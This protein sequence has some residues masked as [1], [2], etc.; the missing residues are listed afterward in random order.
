[1]NS[2]VVSAYLKKLCTK[3]LFVQKVDEEHLAYAKYLLNI[4]VVPMV[5]SNC[6]QKQKTNVL[7]NIRIN[8]RS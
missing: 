8:F 7:R 2:K 4:T 6:H 3:F 5:G 1:M